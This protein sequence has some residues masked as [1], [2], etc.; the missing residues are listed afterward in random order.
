MFDGRVLVIT[1]AGISA[2]S[3]IP[4]FR[5][6]EGYWRNLNPADLATPEAFARDPNLVWEWYR[7]RRA[8]IRAAQP[9]AAHL[10]ITRLAANCR[11]FLLVTQNVDDLHTRAE[12]D[13]CRVST[14]QIVH[15]HG[16]IFSTHCSNC[17]SKELSQKEFDGQLPVCVQCH[18]LMRPGVV[19]FGEQ[20]DLRKVERVEKFLAAGGC[21]LVLV[22]GTTA[23]FGYIIDWAVRAANEN[24]RIIEINPAETSLSPFATEL[25][26]QPAAAALPNVIDVLLK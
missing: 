5:G 20:L 9:N 23:T 24:G 16:D 15:I 7:E 18:S 3:G 19:W 17:D 26:R 6:K 1:G 2:E 4:T 25:L 8:R 13:G 22:I 21:D 12:C 10:A 11:D 14:A